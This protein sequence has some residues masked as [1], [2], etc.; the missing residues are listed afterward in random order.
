MI[1]NIQ[2]TFGIKTYYSA[3]NWQATNQF[4]DLTPI[5]LLQYQHQYQNLNVL[6]TTDF[7]KGQ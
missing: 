3:K 1:K 2:I 6:M 4:T 5:F 7:P